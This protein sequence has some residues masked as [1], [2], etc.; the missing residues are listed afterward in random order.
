LATGDLSFVN[1][2]YPAV[3]TLG[4]CRILGLAAGCVNRQ[5]VSEGLSGN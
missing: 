2:I 1:Y 3:G 5:D 4:H